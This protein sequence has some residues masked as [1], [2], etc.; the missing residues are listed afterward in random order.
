VLG[1]TFSHVVV[2]G[3]VERRQLLWWEAL[4][5]PAEESLADEPRAALQ[6]GAMPSSRRVDQNRF[7]AAME[8][9]AL[10]LVSMRTRT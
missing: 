2:V 7:G 4:L 8:K 9:S 1:V 6:P 10:V 5:T 3:L